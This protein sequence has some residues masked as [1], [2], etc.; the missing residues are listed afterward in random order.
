[1]KQTKRDDFYPHY[2]KAVVVYQVGVANVFEVECFNMADFGRD[3]RR[4]LQSDFNSCEWF[5][6]G[7]GAAGWHVSSMFCNQAGDIVNAK[8]SDYL[9]YAPFFDSM[10]PVFVKVLKEYD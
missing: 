4:M 2:H 7:L 8:W 5:A 9:P 1:M 3:A 10:N 6:R